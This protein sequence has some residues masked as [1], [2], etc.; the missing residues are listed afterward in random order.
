[1]VNL[2]ALERKIERA[3]ESETASEIETAREGGLATVR[4]RARES[5]EERAR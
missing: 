2:I 1:V 4:E 3:S 5:E